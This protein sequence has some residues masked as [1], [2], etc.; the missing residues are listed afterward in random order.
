[1]AALSDLADYDILA[2]S[3]TVYAESSK[4]K[5]SKI[6]QW[7]IKT[8]MGNLVTGDTAPRINVETKWYMLFCARVDAGHYISPTGAEW[9]STLYLWLLGAWIPIYDFHHQMA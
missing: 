6:Q 7:W 3:K 4:L 9:K 1:M 2:N 5:V 8:R